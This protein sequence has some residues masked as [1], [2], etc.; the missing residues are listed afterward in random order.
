[1]HLYMVFG[2][3]LIVPTVDF[4]LAAPVLVQEKRQAC[5]DMANIPECPV[6]VLGKRGEI[7]EVGG[8]YIENWFAK[9][10][11]ESAAL[12]SSSSPP[13]ES[14]HGQVDVNQRLPSVSEGWSLVSSLDHAP[15]P[16]PGPSTE[17]DH[18]LTGVHA[19][20]SSPVFPTWFLT[21][22]GYMGPHASSTEFDSDHM[23]GVEEPPSRPASP[24]T[25]FDTGDGFQVLHTPPP[26]PGTASLTESDREMVDVPPSSPVS[27]TNPDRR[28]MGA[29]S[30]LENLQ[31]VSDVSK[32]NAKESRRISGT[33]R[34]V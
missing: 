22:H 20:L 1:M 10:E 9:P 34:D 30:R 3:L 23:L 16:N 25:E 13:S 7:E 15:P 21:D 26:S 31:A 2:I 5:A 33:A 8:K 19:P 4:A 28:S 27:S 32:G 14:D 6:T 24:T 11:G 12:P 18:E 17:S 29:D